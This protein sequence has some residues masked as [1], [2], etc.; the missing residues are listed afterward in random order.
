ME[1]IIIKP[2]SKKDL[3]HFLKLAQQLDVEVHSFSEYEDLLL[4]AKM[5][6]NLNSSKVDKST[7]LNT[8]TA[9]LD[10]E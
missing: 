6:E 7:V 8:I 5:E 3:A 4:L 9:I 2:K 1:S 10:S